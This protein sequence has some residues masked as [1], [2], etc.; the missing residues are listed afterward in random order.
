MKWRGGYA[1]VYEE[2]W[3]YCNNVE[4][5]GAVVGWLGLT[6]FWAAVGLLTIW[7]SYEAFVNGLWLFY[8]AKETHI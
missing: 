4:R 5:V 6:L 7:V 1:W 3:D 2:L 8:H